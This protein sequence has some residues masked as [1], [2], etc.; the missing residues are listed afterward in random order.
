[1]IYFIAIPVLIA[2]I[3]Y[4]INIFNLWA[5]NSELID[6][7]ISMNLDSKQMVNMTV[8]KIETLEKFKK[9]FARCLI[10]VFILVF[11]F[12]IEMGGG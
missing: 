4:T 3:Y 1:M 5:K 6:Y 9:M 12:M 10:L 8:K 11:L 2:I 7:W